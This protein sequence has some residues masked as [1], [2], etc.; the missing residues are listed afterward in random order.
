MENRLF[1]LGFG[2][3]NLNIS[4]IFELIVRQSYT[5]I[6]QKIDKVIML[7]I[8]FKYALIDANLNISIA[9]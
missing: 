5:I 7:K 6:V 1:D 8:I 3:S 2:T 9:I 4:I